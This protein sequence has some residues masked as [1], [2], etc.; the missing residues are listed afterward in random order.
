S[1]LT[2]VKGTVHLDGDPQ[3]AGFHFRAVNE[4]D[5]NKAQTYFLR[6]SGK[7][8]MGKEANYDP[9]K[10]DDKTMA[11]LPWNA[12]SFVVGGT[13]YTAAYLHRPANRKEADYSE[14]TYGRFGSYFA[15][16]CDAK[17][18]L[19]VDYR[20]WLQEGEMTKEGVEARSA[21]FVKPPTATV[22]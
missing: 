3:H 4:V 18:P 9:K 15:A 1:K 21:D 7:G 14:R 5:K 2:P 16:D 6:P 8:E 17:K 13:R 19:L 22:K 20:L 12:M 10:P 11:N